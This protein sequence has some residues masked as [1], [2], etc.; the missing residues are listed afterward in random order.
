MKIGLI[1][2]THIPTAAKELPRQVATA[3]AGVDLIL[4]AGDIYAVSCLNWLERI[5]PVKAVEQGGSS[6]Y[7]NDGRVAERRVLELGGHSIGMVHE[8]VLR[9]LVGEPFPGAIAAGFSLDDS[10]L[11]ALASF[12]GKKV[13]I[14]VFGHTHEALV[15]EH[16]GVLLINPGSPLL[17]RHIRRLGTVGLLELSHGPPQARLIELASLG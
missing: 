12:F 8:L 1:S 2:D 15:E 7:A 14:V 3:F 13:D 6:Y 16:E 5:A 11:L 17:P 9:G 10:V 4:H